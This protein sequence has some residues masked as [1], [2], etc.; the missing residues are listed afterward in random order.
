MRVATERGRLQHLLS[1][2][3]DQNQT[4][5]KLWRNGPQN[6]S[7][8]QPMPAQVEISSQQSS[9]HRLQKHI[10]KQSVQKAEK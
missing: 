9:E 7:P 1:L 6:D 4:I 10:N 2:E 8:A 5:R 3:I